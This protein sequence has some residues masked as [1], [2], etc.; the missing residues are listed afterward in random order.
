MMMSEFVERTGFQPTADEYDQI[1]SAYY[2]FDGDKDAFCKAFVE[3]GGE[4]KIYKARANEIARLR[5][6]MS[7]IEKEHKKEVAD[8]DRRINELTAELD[9]EL[10]WKPS[11]GAGTNMEQKRYEELAK[12][13]KAMTD[14][15]AKAFIADECGFDP[16]KI[17]ILHEV[18]TYE[19]NKHRRL[20]KSGT[21]D[22]APVYEATDWNYVRFDCACFMYELVNGELRFYCC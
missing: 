4:M 11:D 1:E 7:E 12:Y 16:E 17:R 15:E 14:E 18:N 6:Q 22:R 19:V 5:S 13:G 9:R 8:R 2:A 20:R 10:E 21:F 3:Q